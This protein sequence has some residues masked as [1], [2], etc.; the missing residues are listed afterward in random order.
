MQ[1]EIF[2]VSY[3]SIN[4]A[5][6]EGMTKL[7]VPLIDSLPSQYHN[8][9]TY[10]VGNKRGISKDYK[11]CTP[12]FLYPVICLA[13]SILNKYLLKIAS[14]KIR[15]FKTI[16][17]DYFLSWKINRPV[18]IISST[19]LYRTTIKNKR[20][21]GYNLFYAGNP[22]DREVYQILKEEEIVHGIKINDAYTYKRRT[23][24]GEKALNTFDYYITPNKLTT[25][26]FTKWYSNKI[27][28]EIENYIIP[29]LSNTPSRTL[30]KNRAL[31]FCYIAHP[32]WLKGLY[33]L[34]EAWSK[35]GH[36]NATL[37][38]GGN[39]DQKALALIKKNNLTLNN[40]EL[41]GWVENLNHF[42]KTSD[43]CI[44]PSL[45]DAGPATVTEAMCYGLPVIVTD[46]CGARTLIKEGINGFVVPSRDAEAIAEKI[47]WFINNPDKLL[48]MKKNSIKTVTNLAAKKQQPMVAEKLSM[49]I[50]NLKH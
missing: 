8:A 5:K 50:E 28:V 24:F 33:Y 47:I 25:K 2:F 48:A 36:L 15:H 44:V 49:I 13:L 3:Q 19:Y 42:F 45:I 21:G 27:V 12:H 34:L 6:L 7:F 14:Y 4:H 29:Q 22:N 10:V 46:G 40:V 32:F 38:V 37:K 23:E 43:V 9:T 20:L 35:L 30:S 16:L 39:F 26:S 1:K 18:I 41:V 31:T 11:I 17:F